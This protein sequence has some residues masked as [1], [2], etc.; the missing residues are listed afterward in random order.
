MVRAIWAIDHGLTFNFD[1]NIRTV[2]FE[3][4]SVEY[5]EELIADICNLVKKVQTE[6]DFSNKIIECLEQ[7]EIDG[8]ITR[9]KSMSLEGKFPLLNPSVN[10]PW[11]LL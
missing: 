3:F 10:V 7:N 4:V 5:P 6:N 1:T 8:L 11:P 9:A 2:M